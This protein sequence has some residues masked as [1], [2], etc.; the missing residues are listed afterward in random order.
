MADATTNPG[1]GDLYADPAA[2]ERAIRYSRTRE[3]LVLVGMVW[4]GAASVLALV[5]GG[6]ARL[7]DLARRLAPGK[8]GPVMPYTLASM[9]LAFL[10]SLPLSYYG[11][12][13]VEQRYDLS[14]Q[15]RRAWLLEQLK[16]L[17]VGAVLGLPIVQTVYWIF[18]RFPRYWW[19]ILSGLTI[20]FSVVLVNLAPVLILPLFNK[21]QP[22]KDRELVDRIK[23]LAAGEG[24]KVSDVLQMDMSKQTKKPNAFFTGVGNTKR[25]VLADTLLESFT[26]DE[27]EVV[28]AH[29]LA[30]QVHRDLWKGIVLGAL[31]TVVTL[32]SAHRLVPRLVG[33][34]G[35][36]W[37]L[38]T[39]RGVEDV[40]ALPLLTLVT[41]TMS[42]ALSP[43]VNA[44]TRSSVEHAADR[45][46]LELTNKP[47]AFVS[48]MEKLGRLSLSDP[49]PPAIVKHFLY[50]H[51][52]LQERIEYGRSFEAI[53]AE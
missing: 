48:A 22:L 21:Y 11:G 31:T 32:F 20:P 26:A 45:Y 46:A 42:L 43:F 3:W 50:N 41:G 37:G 44:W 16:G 12:Y 13:A 14:N 8:L 51:P 19:A 29:E 39:E 15:T 10:S 6:S 25:I 27:V 30:H 17:G 24:V 52:P 34:F 18:R 2:R 33:R 53:R 5:T 49:K 35:A 9:I 4:S 40:A 36:R 28:L 38:E 23:A 7:R 1:K 47:A